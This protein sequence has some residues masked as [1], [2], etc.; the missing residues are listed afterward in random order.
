MKNELDKQIHFL[1]IPKDP[2][3]GKNVILEM[4]P[5]KSYLPFYM[6]DIVLQFPQDR[7]VP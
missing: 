5:Y 3:D 6:N 2:N 7:N 4:L 1:L